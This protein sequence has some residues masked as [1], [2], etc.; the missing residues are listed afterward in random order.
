MQQ[1]QPNPPA[2]Q[3][4]AP[5]PPPAPPKGWVLGAAYSD[6]ANAGSS[7]STAND[8]SADMG[9]A[10]KETDKDKDTGKGKD[11]DGKRKKKKKGGGKD[12]EKPKSA[13]DKHK[14]VAG[15]YAGASFQ[16]SPEPDDLPKPPAYMLVDD[17]FETSSG[18]PPVASTTILQRG[19]ERGAREAVRGEVASSVGLA[20][21][22]L[23]S[24]LN[25]SGSQ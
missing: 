11:G 16:N 19:G 18:N 2:G 1:L 10:N 22:E 13:K 20:T 7:K 15:P 6:V 21:S 8:G 5:P 24:M 9:E 12:T 14:H 25:I 4:S 23:R 3:A 17:G